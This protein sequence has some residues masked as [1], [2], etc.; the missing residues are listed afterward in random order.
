MALVG[1]MTF[2]VKPGRSDVLSGGKWGRREKRTVLVRRRR[3][4]RQL[5]QKLRLG[6]GDPWREGSGRGKEAVACM[7]KGGRVDVIDVRQV[8]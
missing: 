7:S 4:W 5:L 3:R 6:R 2:R 8:G 1:A